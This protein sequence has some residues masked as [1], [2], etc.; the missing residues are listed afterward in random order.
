MNVKFLLI[1]K[2]ECY[3]FNYFVNNKKERRNKQIL[4]K[5]D[6]KES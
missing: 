3:N 1:Y 6:L 2:M 5:S 4:L